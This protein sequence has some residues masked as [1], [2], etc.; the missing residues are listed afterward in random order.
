MA[1]FSFEQD[2][3]VFRNR[4]ALTEQYTPDELV[5]RDEELSEFHAALQPV[6]NGENPSNIFIYGKSGVGKTAATRFLLQ[7]L[8]RDVADVDEV[9]LTTIEVNCDG[10]NTSYQTAVE[11]VNRMRDPG[12]EMSSTGYPQAA[13]YNGLWE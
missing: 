1:D 4:D 5:G 3:R 8:E 12:N 13:V 7:R 11:L 9:D 2:T 6:I 10:L